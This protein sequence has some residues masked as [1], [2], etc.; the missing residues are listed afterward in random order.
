MSYGSFNFETSTANTSVFSDTTLVSSHQVTTVAGSSAIPEHTYSDGLTLDSKGQVANQS[1]SHS[2]PTHGDRANLD[3]ALLNRAREII[4][5]L[6]DEED[7]VRIEIDFQSLRGSVLSLWETAANASVFHQEILSI[8]E[9]AILSIDV[10]VKEQLL[11]FREAVGDL[12][13]DP[14]TQAHVDVIR[15]Q[16]IKRGFNPLAILD[17]MDNIDG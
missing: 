2:A 1:K 16:F 4:N 7:P 3:R 14:I 15:A 9:S 12:E 10:P 11:V 8:L 6:M 5:S 17:C 13:A